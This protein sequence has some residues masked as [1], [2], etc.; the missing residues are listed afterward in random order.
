MGTAD[1]LPGHDG[2]T[3]KS[4]ARRKQKRDRGAEGPLPTE[5]AEAGAAEGAADDATR[6]GE[7]AGP[8]PQP[9][10]ELPDGAGQPAADPAGEA[11]PEFG[12]LAVEYDF[13]RVLA[14]GTVAEVYLAR[15]RSSGRH[16]AI[17]RIRA[18]LSDDPET[19]ARF[20]REA[21]IVAGLDHPG[22]VRTLAVQRPEPGT[23]AIVMQYVPWPTLRTVL[24]EKRALP[25]D[26]VTAI[27]RHLASAL[28]YAQARGIVHRDVKP[29]N[30]FVHPPTDRTLLADFGS[31]R[32]IAHDAPVT[33]TGAAIGTPTYMSPE[34]IAGRPL[35]GRS[36][37]YSLGLVGWEMLSG[38]RPWEGEGLYGVLHRQQHDDLPPLAELRPQ[39]PASLLFAVEGLLH[40]DPAERWPDAD[41]FLAALL[42]ERPVRH[43][44][45][46]GVVS[47][48]ASSIDEPTLR[49]PLDAA[50]RWPRPP[51]LAAGDAEVDD[52]WDEEPEV[53]RDRGGQP[54]SS[55]M[56]RRAPL[57]ATA[58]VALAVLAGAV[59][60]QGRDHGS[61]PSEMVP[62]DR[63]SATDDS[64]AATR[65]G[66]VDVATPPA[67]VRPE[68]RASGSAG[69]P[70]AAAA[71][72]EARI[73]DPPATPTGGRTA[74]G[75]A[76][77]TA[78]ATESRS[79]GHADSLARCASTALA[80]Q[81]ACL[82]ARLHETD[83]PMNAVYQAV[84][85]RLRQRAGVPT[86]APDPPAVQRLRAQQRAWLETRDRE[87]RRMAG[88][89]EPPRWAPSRARCLA[90]FAAD[91]TAELR[92]RLR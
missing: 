4:S 35:D 17:K 26:R 61:S 28:R 57:L 70:G 27:L 67:S 89:Q 83:A 14:R 47:A 65:G 50:S 21:R 31:A 76:T 71:E 86:R 8:A 64:V 68:P 32:P 41:A 69:A 19:V 46:V 92:A 13:L 84:I 58:A 10:D 87:C 11:P 42:R 82:L 51:A 49:L 22:I 23:L 59:M 37:L 75:R 66:E 60:L 48:A 74:T 79:R 5:P 72:P 81:R 38:E 7:H 25:F 85:R 90:A 53:G 12:R 56:K 1:A 44:A 62:V 20:A 77:R 9:A 88:G 40:K 6:P 3:M 2:G 24:A 36:D 34:Q 30:V 18:Q 16:V 29:D 15:D 33:L 55:A 52:D 80:D 63:V 91:R 73:T 54:A 45:G 78:G 43:T 39:I